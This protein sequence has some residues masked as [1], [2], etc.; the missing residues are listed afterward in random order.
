M[1]ITWPKFARP[2]LEGKPDCEGHV[3]EEDVI[4]VEPAG[5]PSTCDDL[6][7]N[8]DME[9]GLLYWGHRNHYSGTQHG[10]LLSVRE[11]I[12]GSAALRYYNRSSGY[13]GMGQSLDT[14]CLHRN[15][16]GFYEIEMYFRLENG[17]I[18]FICDRFTSDWS[19]RCPLIT[20]QKQKLVNGELISK[21]PHPGE[22]E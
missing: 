2:R 8:G 16:N 20:L 22:V 18:P 21:Y 7:I 4:V 11:G 12:D 6:I 15:L 3:A 10:E 9:Q 17:T 5:S 13:H 19:V 1:Q 14:R